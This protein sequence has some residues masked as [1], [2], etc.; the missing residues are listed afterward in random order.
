MVIQMTGETSS[1]KRGS[2]DFSGYFCSRPF[3]F[4]E[5]TGWQKPKGDVFVCCPTWLDTPIGNIRSGSMDEI[6]N[7]P[8]AQEVRQSILDGS[9]KYCR[10]SR[11][12]FL[13]MKTGPV[14][15]LEDVDDPQ[16]KEV[17]EKRLTKLPYGPREVTC[18]FDKSCNLSCP[19]CRT[20]LI[21]ENGLR[22]EIED[23]QSKLQS[24]WLRDA[25]WMSITGSGDPFGSPFFRK[26][27]RSMRRED[28]PNL[29]TLHLISNGLLW[30]PHNWE[31][32]P[33]DIR[34]L[35][36]TAAIS[37]DAAR[38][39]TYAVNRRRGNFDKLLRNLEFVSKLRKNG[40]INHMTISMVVQE[41][42]FEE[43]PEFVA[44][45]KRFGF[46]L[47]YFSQL[48]DWGTYPK[49]EL[50]NRQVH[51]LEHPRHGDLL[52]VLQMPELRDP[53]V[54]LGNLTQLREQVDAQR[55]A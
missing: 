44:L 52:E 6:W 46:D 36:R 28:L 33:A 7:G 17:I 15:K 16:M 30:T 54:F 18:S 19:S 50:L 9:Y 34:A 10:L 8:T 1:K 21:I 24:Q 45:A 14:Q 29:E 47:V 3:T 55:A 22:D 40:P 13:Q 25:R 26:W 27:L 4:V 43:M 39:D 20:E 31:A 11:C 12:G 32:I 51:R 53:I 2:E 38:P 42:N 48:V 37:I 41:N 35:V 23:I 49:E 5:V